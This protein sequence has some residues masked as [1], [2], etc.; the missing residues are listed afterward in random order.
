[1]NDP[2]LTAHNLQRAA[3]AKGGVFRFD[4]E[5]IRIR[6][7]GGRV[8][9]VTFADDSNVDANVVVNAAGPHSFVINKMA[10]VYHSMN[11]ETR[12]LRHDVHHVPSPPGLDFEADGIHTSAADLEIYIRP[13]T[14]NNIL[15]GSEDPECDPKIWVDD[16]DK[17]DDSV[18]GHQWDAQVL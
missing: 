11:I 16:P 7:L 17:Y 13:E 5:V 3:Q 1:M 15:I 8:Q 2:Q 4:T 18:S 9:G 12:A 6:R 14:G 10:G